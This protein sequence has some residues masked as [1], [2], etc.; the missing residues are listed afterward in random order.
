MV[1]NEVIPDNKISKKFNRNIFSHGR[2]TCF[3]LADTDTF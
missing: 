1:N 2:F 3:V